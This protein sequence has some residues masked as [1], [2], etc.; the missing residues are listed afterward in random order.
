MLRKP[1]GQDPARAVRD[2]GRLRL[3]PSVFQL[4]KSASAPLAEAHDS[5][6]LACFDAFT[7]LLQ[8]RAQ[9]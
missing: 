4:P 7:L 9:V 5:P 6:C 2:I 3:F 8:Q 1:A